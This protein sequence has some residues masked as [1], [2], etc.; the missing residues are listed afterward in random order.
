MKDNSESDF[1]ANLKRRLN[2]KIDF[3]KIILDFNVLL[4]RSVKL[5]KLIDFIQE[6]DFKES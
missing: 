6:G 1:Q 4:D 3:D 5:K 2:S